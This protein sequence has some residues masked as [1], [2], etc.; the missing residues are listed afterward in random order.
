MWGVTSWVKSSGPSQKSFWGRVKGF[1][2]HCQRMR[3]H[4][5]V[6]AWH[7]RTRALFTLS[8]V[9]TGQDSTVLGRG[10]NSCY[11]PQEWQQQVQEL[12]EQ[13]CDWLMGN[14]GAAGGKAAWLSALPPQTQPALGPHSPGR[15]KAT[16]KGESCHSG[17]PGLSQHS[18]ESAA[19]LSRRV[20]LQLQGLR[21]TLSLH[22]TA[23]CSGIAEWCQGWHQLTRHL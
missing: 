4:L 6:P 16:V 10:F 21:A 3:W 9:S 1:G 19:P 13:G 22:V 18:R 7:Q 11:I 20:P 17:W 5:A 14:F 12:A 2:M 23:G 15:D 8:R